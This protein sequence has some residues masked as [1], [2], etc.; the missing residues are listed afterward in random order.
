MK[1]RHPFCTPLMSSEYASANVN[2]IAIPDKLDISQGIRTSTRAGS[3]NLEV[4][5]EYQLHRPIY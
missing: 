4:N 5:N 2:R 1:C 3:T